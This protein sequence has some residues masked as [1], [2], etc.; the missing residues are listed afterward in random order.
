MSPTATLLLLV[1]LSGLPMLALGLAAGYLLTRP[2]AVEAAGQREAAP[3]PDAGLVRELQRSILDINDQ[4]GRQREQLVRIA[5]NR[6]RP[7]RT[8]REVAEPPAAIRVPPLPPLDEPA[9]SS[10]AQPSRAS[11][12]VG[13]RREAVQRLVAEGLSDR[14]IAR[15]LRIGLEEVRLIGSSAAPAAARNPRKGLAS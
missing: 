13:G 11:E 2:R 9:P 10:T 14:A 6:A 3:A 15:Q 7:E 5:E 12:G 1:L 4:L 8:R